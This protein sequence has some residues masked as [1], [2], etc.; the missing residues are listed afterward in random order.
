MHD[1]YNSLLTGDVIELHR[2]RVSTIVNHV[3]ASIVSP[4]GTP[5]DERPPVPSPDDRLAKYKEKRFAKLHRRSLRRAA[6]DGHEAAI[7]KVSELDLKHLELVKKSTVA[8]RKRAEK[9]MTP[10]QKVTAKL[11][12]KQGPVNERSRDSKAKAM[13]FEAKAVENLEEARG[14]EKQLAEQGL[15]A[16]SLFEDKRQGPVSKREGVRDNI[17]GSQP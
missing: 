15:E 12:E 14:K 13:K 1:P 3:V 16:E 9:K 6:K 7:Q 10:T 11:D 17:Y 8:S 2:L 5:I 4:F